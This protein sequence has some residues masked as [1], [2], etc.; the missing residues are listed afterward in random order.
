M[1]KR[2]SDINIK[3]VT[4]DVVISQG[5]KGGVTTHDTINKNSKPN[6]KSFFTN[7][8]IL[9]I[10]FIA[11]VL[12]ILAYF[13]LQPVLK[14]SKDNLEPINAI[15]KN[16]TTKILNDK[17]EQKPLIQ[18]VM[19][20]TK[21]V[22]NENE[23]PIS[24]SN[25]TGDVVV[26]QNQTGGITAH[27]VNIN[28]AQKRSI[29]NS[30]GEISQALKQYPI[31]A[32]RLEYSSSDPENNSLALEIDKLLIGL[33]WQRFDPVIRIAGPQ[34][35]PGITIYML[36]QAEPMITLANQLWI[37][38]GSKG[39]EG[40]IVTDLDNIFKIHGWPNLFSNCYTRCK[41]PRY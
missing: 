20:K 17:P 38:L 41:I 16:D 35:T 11:S 33:N 31:A 1:K 36:K 15:Y 28:K 7:R 3:N 2:N 32:Y 25:V 10:G 8:Y 9:L 24:V 6:D 39:V 12:G 14:S 22:N 29:A 27:T 4:G 34:H 23:K 13:G 19:K 5:Q 26:S 37:A 30:I 18:P 21:E 40:Q